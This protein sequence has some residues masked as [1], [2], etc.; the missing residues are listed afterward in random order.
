L[1]LRLRLYQLRL[2]RGLRRLG[3]LQLAWYGAG[4]TTNR[5][6]AFLTC[7]PSW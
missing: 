4:S 6:S 3:L 5:V 2:G 7:A 1:E